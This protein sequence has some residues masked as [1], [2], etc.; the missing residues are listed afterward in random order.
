[1]ESGTPPFSANTA[2]KLQIASVE[3]TQMRALREAVLGLPGAVGRLQAIDNQITAL[4]AQ[5]TAE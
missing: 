5:L 1:M 4:R 3:A 2:L